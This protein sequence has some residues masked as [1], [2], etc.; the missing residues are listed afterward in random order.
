[1]KA[2]VEVDTIS[3][4]ASAGSGGRGSYAWPIPSDGTT[5][6]DYKVSIQSI[7]QPTLKDASNKFTITTEQPANYTRI[8]PTA[9]FMADVTDVKAPLAVQ[10]T[11]KSV[12]TG[13]AMYKWKFI[14]E[15]GHNHEH[16]HGKEPCWLPSQHPVIKP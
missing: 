16:Q 5:G 10:F 2:S 6:D 4:R 11:D 12:T 13:A 7:S 9:Q 14:D 15:D 3:P 1:M 8:P